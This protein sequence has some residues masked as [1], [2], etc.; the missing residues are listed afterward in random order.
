MTQ[1]LQ[2]N[3][4]GSLHAT[5]KFLPLIRDG[6]RLVNVASMAGFL[7]NYSPA[8]RQQFLSSQTVEDVT[9][10]VEAFRHAVEQG[11]HT[12]Q[13]WPSSG[14]MVSKAGMIG[15][16]RVLAQDKEVQKRGILLNSC[17][18]GYVNTD[19]TKGRGFR[20]VDRGAQTP[21]MLALDNLEG[22]SGDFW[23]SEKVSPLTQ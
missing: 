11:N 22:V 14:Y 12:K 3:Y 6:G 8:I 15:F 13:G 20:T 23:Q 19:M 17:C 1:T 16:T 4:Y 9:T 5:Q 18:P 10:L 2:C 7:K 21:V